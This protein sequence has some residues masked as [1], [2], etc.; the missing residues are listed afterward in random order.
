MHL[1]RKDIKMNDETIPLK[2]MIEKALEKCND[3]ELL[4]FIYKLMVYD[5]KEAEPIHTE[6]NT[7]IV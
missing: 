4:D 7:A 6:N 3:I 1:S 2:M 5:T